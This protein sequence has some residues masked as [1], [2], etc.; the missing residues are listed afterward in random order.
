M[1]VEKGDTVAVRYTGRLDNGEVFDSNDEGGGGIT[2][3]CSSGRSVGLA[4]GLLV[5]FRM[6]RRR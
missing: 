6:R 3:G 4:L 1:K 2:G 5:A